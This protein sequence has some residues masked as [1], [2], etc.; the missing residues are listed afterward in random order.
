MYG[1][2]RPFKPELRIKEFELYKAAYCGL[3]HA[4][5]R[6]YGFLARFAVSYDMAFFVLTASKN[7]GLCKKKCPARL[8]KKR[9]CVELNDVLIT[10]ATLTVLLAWHKQEDARRDGG[11]FKKLGALFFR[12]FFRR[13]YKKAAA[14]L[15]DF[16]GLCKTQLEK[17]AVL[18]KSGSTSLDETADCFASLLAGFSLTAADAATARIYKE[19][20]YHLGRAVYILDAVDDHAEDVHRKRYNV[21]TAAGVRP[22]QITETVE[23]SL[24]AAA[25]AF[26]LLPASEFTPIAGNIL[27]L[28]MPAV[29]NDVLKG[30]MR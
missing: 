25:A 26:E 18:E 11:A 1:Y 13:K 14:K 23:Y 8:F 21:F 24:A 7:P 19:L 6:E 4:L 22:A 29:L 10:A 17:L 2:V 30:K 12:L 28:G 5:R 15:P 20:F 16:A 9:A 3:C 27:Y